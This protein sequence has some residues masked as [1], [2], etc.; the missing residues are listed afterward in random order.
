MG[1]PVRLDTIT[2]ATDVID[3]GKALPIVKWAGG[4]RMILPKLMQYLPP[5][6]SEDATYYEPFLGGAAFFLALAPRRAVLGDVNP[7]LIEMY[8]A[9]RDVPA[10]VTAR[11]DVMQPHAQDTDYYYQVRALKPADLSL[12]ERAAR[13]IFLNKT[14][15][16]G[17]YRVNASG[18]FNVP[19]G[20][21]AQ[22]PTLYDPTNLARVSR[23]LRGADLRCTDFEAVLAGAGRDD[24]VYLDPPY[25]PLTTTAN[26]TRYTKGS[27]TEED[28]RRLAR[29]MHDLHERGASVLLSNSDTPLVRELY[30]DFHIEE[31]HAPR[32]INSDASGRRNVRELAIH[33]YP[34][35]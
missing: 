22:R 33:T 29:T 17:L 13:L 11:L 9:V 26:F 21:Y 12:P 28:Q 2:K 16:N 6:L 8:E 15:Y 23:L 19:F 1:L 25:V 10:C 27:F 5:K 7:D 3:T 24:F 34:L 35:A 20:R 31:V 32:L 4:K 30:A 14:C 18:Q